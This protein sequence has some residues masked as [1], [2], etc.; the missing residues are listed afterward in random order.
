MNTPRKLRFLALWNLISGLFPM[1]AGATPATFELSL[2]S[3]ETRSIDTSDQIKSLDSSSQAAIEAAKASNIS[4]YPTLSFKADYFY[5]TNIPTLVLP[6]QGHPGFPM[7]THDN[8]GFGPALTYT[9]WDSGANW[10]TYK[11]ANLQA[12]ARDEDKKAATL[13]LLMLTRASYVRLQL[14]SEELRLLYSSLELAR[15]QFHDIKANF[16][17]GAASKLDQVDAERDVI[18]YGLQFEQKQ[19]EVTA[20]L[21]D[22]LALIREPA[23]QDVSKPGPAGVPEISLL[24]KLDSQ[25]ALLNDSRFLQYSPPDEKQPML[26]SLE[27]QA[28]SLDHSAESEKGKYFPK[29]DLSAT[30]MWQYP[31]ELLPTTEEQNTFMVSVTIPLSEGLRVNHQVAEKR[32]EAEAIRFNKSQSKVNMDRDY[33]KAVAL[34]TS[35]RAQQKMSLEDVALSESAAKL[36]Y[37]SYRAGKINLIDV[38]SA[39]NRALNA[40]VNAARTNAQVLN[41][42]FT[43]NLISGERLK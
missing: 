18:N 30:A 9:L 21:K 41:Q 42:L 19:A 3:A 40:K 36:Y 25:D 33:E 31:Y 39:N 38:Q 6:V 26:R 17:A 15:A 22:L 37:Q 23:P 10:N 32:R 12:V 29:V 13:N 28:E 27:I 2:K 34:I 8:Y 43:L 35:L 14:A 20:D 1:A 7:G 11:S 5:L 24:L 4:L 16:R